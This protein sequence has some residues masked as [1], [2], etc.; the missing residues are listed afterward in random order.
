MY[1]L[2]MDRQIIPEGERAVQKKY[3]RIHKNDLQQN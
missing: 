3:S 2:V 1:S